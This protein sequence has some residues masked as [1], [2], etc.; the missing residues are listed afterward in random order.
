MSG[1]ALYSGIVSEKR[2]GAAAALQTPGTPALL[3]QP[4]R[5]HP[6]EGHSSLVSRGKSAQRSSIGLKVVGLNTT[7]C[8]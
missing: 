7:R 8:L 1:A 6:S 5:R 3:P 2:S 4:S